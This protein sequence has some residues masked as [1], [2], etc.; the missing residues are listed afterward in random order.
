A[1]VR[2]VKREEVGAAGAAMVAALS[3]GILPDIDAACARWVTPLLAEAEA[4]DP[5]LVSHYDRLFPQYRASYRSLRPVW[6]A[7]EDLRTR[8]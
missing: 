4:P 3:L 8:G 5:A 6:H 2:L 7:L 1:P